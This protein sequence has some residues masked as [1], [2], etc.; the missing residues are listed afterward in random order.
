MST[1][2]KRT[3]RL[4]DFFSERG[5]QPILL[6]RSG[7][8]PPDLYC[9]ADSR[10]ERLGPL[11]KFVSPEAKFSVSSP[12]PA[13]DLEAVQTDNR[14][15][16]VEA[17]FFKKLLQLLGV[18]GSADV[19]AD[20]SNSVDAEYLFKNVTVR[21]VAVPDI[22][23]AIAKGLRTNYLDKTAL[24]DG[25]YHVAYEYLY[26]EQVDIVAGAHAGTKVELDANVSAVA[27]VSGGFASSGKG[28]ERDAYSGHPEPAAVAFKAG[29][30]VRHN[31][32]WALRTISTHSAGFDPD[33]PVDYL[34]DRGN[35]LTIADIEDQ[36]RQS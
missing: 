30:I 31:G 29:P 19:M 15:I 22:I 13:V 20:V 9:L 3:D 11:R 36:S 24:S 12:E 32:Q 21:S 16:D 2:S 7:L 6:A 23:D 8:L 27:G 5:Y 34:F 18:A 33:G 10:F 25:S 4:F 28:S 26:A 17:K 14:K 35:F 1:G